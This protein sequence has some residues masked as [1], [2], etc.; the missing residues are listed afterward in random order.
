MDR[1][2]DLDLFMVNHAEIFYNA[3]FTT[4]KLRSLRNP[5]YEIVCTGTMEEK[6]QTSAAKP[7]I[8]E[9]G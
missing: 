7:G 2:G 5:S 3:F 9:V 6:L 1:D 8:H 4:S